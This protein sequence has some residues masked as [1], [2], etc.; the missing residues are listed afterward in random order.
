[1][2]DVVIV[3]KNEQRHLGAVLSALAA[4]ENV[5]EKINVFVVDNG[6]TDATVA[7]AQAHGAVTINCQGSQRLARKT[8]T[9]NRTKQQKANHNT[10][11]EPNTKRTV[12]LAKK[13]ENEPTLGAA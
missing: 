8:N 3:A 2:I 10:Q 5:A 4:Q 1:M 12:S 6:S 9:A 11:T 7:I 13:F